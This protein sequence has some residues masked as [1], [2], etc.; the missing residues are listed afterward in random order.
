[1]P[2]LSQ[3]QTFANF[4]VTSNYA[5]NSTTSIQASLKEILGSGVQ[6]RLNWKKLPQPAKSTPVGY[7]KEWRNTNNGHYSYSHTE[8]NS[9]G[10]QFWHYRDGPYSAVNFPANAEI[11]DVV[12]DASYKAKAKLFVGLQGEGANIANM[13][14][15]RQQSIDQITKTVKS[16]YYLIH[17]LRR[18]DLT[19]AIRRL[20][21][22][23]PQKIA[24][25]L[26][27]KD[28]ADQWIGLQYGWKPLL[29]DIYD[30]CEGAH[31]RSSSPLVV[32]KGTGHQ[33]R[34]AKSDSSWTF[35][36]PTCYGLRQ[37]SATAKYM[38]RVRP[39]LTYATANA[40]GLL[41][42]L[43]VAW[44]VLPWS[45]VV[46]WFLPVG[47]YINQWSAPF[48]WYFIDGCFSTLSKSMESAQYTFVHDYTSSGWTYT[49]HESW[50]GDQSYVN[51]GRS[52]LA[53][54]PMPDPPRAKNPVS[55]AHFAN[56]LAL[57]AQQFHR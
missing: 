15:E 31:Q 32:V 4:V 10:L 46:D 11:P 53:N 26:K 52:V 33:S 23:D 7:Q 25:P 50:F 56:A 30:I 29:A 55:A 39:D 24:R 49:N 12:S 8:S 9:G 36:G 14:A 1:M 47:N 37:T 35:T 45:F 28:I 13:F 54:F 20:G 57:F 41:N 43:T 48:G 42:P 44:E 21:H 22:G 27:G 3:K 16:L 2:L 38:V 17:D 19:S 40:L 6:K 5:G 18:G 34:T 51:F